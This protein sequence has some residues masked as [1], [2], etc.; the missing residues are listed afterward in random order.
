MS[1]KGKIKKVYKNKDAKTPLECLVLLDKTGLVSFKSA[2][3][4]HSL[5]KKAKEKTDLEAARGMQKAK[6]DLFALFNR[7]GHKNPTGVG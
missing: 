3:M 5:L 7:P 4:L 2:T 1:D 6:A